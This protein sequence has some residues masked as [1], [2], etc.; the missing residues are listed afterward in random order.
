MSTI[1]AHAPTSAPSVS[2]PEF[3]STC[4]PWCT[5]CWKGGSQYVPDPGVTFHHGDVRTIVCTNGPE[6]REVEISLERLDAEG[7]TGSTQVYVRS[8]AGAFSMSLAQAEL[9]AAE[10]FSL[11]LRGRQ[12]A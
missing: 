1:I 7:E 5:D 12:S 8:E 2:P 10:L 11:V 4:P 3:P 6:K 9:L